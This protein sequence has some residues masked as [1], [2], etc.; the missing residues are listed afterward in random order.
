MEA[1]P[2]AE[3]EVDRAFLLDV[4]VR[5]RALVVELLPGKDQALL[6][7]G[8]ALFV[9]YLA[10]E[11]VNGVGGLDLQGDGLSGQCLNKDLHLHRPHGP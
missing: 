10:L 5:Q 6:V 2:Q 11:H 9:L 4:V 3:D 8:D 7:G 1:P